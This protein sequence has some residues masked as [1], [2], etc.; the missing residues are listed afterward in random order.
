[1]SSAII[2]LVAALVAAIVAALL[3]RVAGL[4]ARVAAETRLAEAERT[5]ARLLSERDA[6]RLAEA[7]AASALAAADQRLADEE[8]RRADFAHLKEEFLTVSRA[9]VMG[10]GQELSSKLLED[11]KRENAEAKK[12]GEEQVRL[13]ADHLVKQLAQVADAVAQL[14]G[15]VASDGARLETVLRALSNPSGA[16]QFAEIGLANTLRSFGLE[17]GRDFALQP[18]TEDIETGRRRR[19]D[20]VVFLPG[21][22]LLVIDCKASKFLLDIAEQEGGEA[23]D[24]AYERLARTMNQHLKDLAG[25]DYAGA[26]AAD[27]RRSGQAGGPRRILSVMYLPNEGA[28]EKLHRADPG[29]TQRAAGLQIIPAGP[30][31]LAC[32]VGFASNEISLARQIENREQIVA[33]VQ[34]LLDGIGLALGHTQAL[35][36]GLKAAAEGFEKLTRSVNRSLLPRARRLGRL[37]VQAGKPL[38]THL[39]GFE[40][41]LGESELIEGEAEELGE[42]AGEPGDLPILVEKAAQ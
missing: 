9:A 6:A 7:K 15:R 22:S 5:M 17:E 29:F 20:A 26:I 23:E 40:V 24:A 28:V 35:G 4:P 37:G 13:A 41:R 34:A 33:L 3:T 18:S 27:Y 14:H 2:G 11:H 16:G 38:P 42:A 8:R 36:R 12:A 39:A 32:I 30:A 21:D 25:R 1:M 19:P 10:T 31:G